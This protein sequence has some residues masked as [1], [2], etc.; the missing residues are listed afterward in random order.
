MK[1]KRVIIELG[2][3]AAIYL[4]AC[5]I[6]P[7]LF[8]LLWGNATL[9]IKL[10]DTYFVMSISPWQGLALWTFSLISTLIYFIRAIIK[11]Y[12]NNIINTIL[13]SSSFLLTLTLIKI[14]RMILL[15]EQTM[16]AN[17]EGWTIY[18]PLSRLHTMPA[19]KT[20]HPHFDSYMFIPII[21]FMLILVAS[22]I[23]TGK[24]WKTNTHEQHPL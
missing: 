10:H 5:V 24:N 19:S 11:R 4:M 9:D 8:G 20:G 6:W 18:P 12:K 17:A 22:S 1:P 23:L 7:V 21:I 16:N 2:I 13:I 15:L 3:L 14:Y